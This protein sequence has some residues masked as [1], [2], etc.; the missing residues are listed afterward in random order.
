MS[1][2]NNIEDKK[3]IIITTTVFVVVAFFAI[4]G[5]VVNAEG[6]L[7][8]NEVGDRVVLNDDW[9]LSINDTEIGEVDLDKYSFEGLERGDEIKLCTSGISTHIQATV[10]LLTLK[11]C[12]VTVRQNDEIVYS[13]G[14]DLYKEGK[15]TG[16]GYHRINLHS[17]GKEDLIEIDLIVS[18]KN[19]FAS[20]TAPEIRDG[21][22][23]SYEMTEELMIPGV[24]SNFFIVFGLCLI[25]VTVFLAI[26]NAMER[27]YLFKIYCIALFSVSAGFW[28]FTSSNIAMFYSV[29]YSDK[30]FIEYISLFFMPLAILSYQIDSNLREK[31]GIVR[32][33][34]YEIL[35]IADAAFFV[36]SIVCHLTGTLS[37]VRFLFYDHIISTILLLFIMVTQL[38]DL[39]NRKSKNY[40]AMI[41]VLLLVAA[42]FFE[43][44]RYNVS[45][46]II[47]RDV[48]YKFSI[49]FVAGLLFV[50]SLLIDYARNAIATL[51]DSARLELIEKMAY[52]DSLTQIY[53]R[54]AAERRYKSLDNERQPYCIIEFDMNGLKRINDIYGHDEGD[55]YIRN[56]ANA[57]S[58]VFS[59]MGMVC[60]TGGDE[61]TIIVDKEDHL[62]P[63]TIKN[64][65]SSLKTMIRRLSDWH[66]DW[67]LSAAY[68]Y[69]FYN[70]EGI[71]SVS[72]AF[73][74]AD[75][76]M[77]D[78][79]KEMKK[80]NKT[81][82]K[83]KKKK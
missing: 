28:I 3:K 79:K 48:T 7:S 45:K 70:E 46:Y 58:C 82:K 49:L 24:L 56:F 54:M 41:G 78:M 42:G 21:R 83:A 74:K 35:W 26:V 73:K 71:N 5:I 16:S 66:E 11:N 1:Y 60:R 19:A 50:W 65:L 12:A 27:M 51:K 61:F 32:Y 18:E 76:R 30:T 72:D 53:N 63:V 68:G 29:N 23:I 4:L 20:L 25:L 8:K 59:N 39:I 81:A 62:L 15:I 44:L 47:G 75:E 6:L 34:L 43:V 64:S 40:I 55:E 2:G 13:Y 52:T 69:C 33:R 10:L 31:A 36:F 38:Y 77:Y 57:L 37:I 67:N 17:L 14:V 9:D 80:E 22:T